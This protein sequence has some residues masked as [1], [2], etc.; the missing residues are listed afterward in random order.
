MLFAPLTVD[1]YTSQLSSLLSVWPTEEFGAK[2]YNIP[3]SPQP[4][5]WNED[6]YK[7]LIRIVQGL[8][9]EPNYESEQVGGGA[10]RGRTAWTGS[11]TGKDSSASC[12]TSPTLKPDAS[13]RASR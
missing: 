8:L 7:S 3:L 13:C 12:E 1:G 9:E 2:V 6:G 4:V 5:L 11:H 10:N